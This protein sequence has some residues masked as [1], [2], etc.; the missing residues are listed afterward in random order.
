MPLS[1]PPEADVIEVSLFGPGYG[2]SCVIHLGSNDWIVV[3]SCIDRS[4][5]E[6]A[7]L[8]YF[9]RM[10]LSPESSV[11]LLVATHAHDDHIGGLSG[12]VSACPDAPLVCSV[13]MNSD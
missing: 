3:D 11:R 9:G 7:V 12:L 6:N 8:A 10:G 4:V 13:A 2:E 5:G 1:D